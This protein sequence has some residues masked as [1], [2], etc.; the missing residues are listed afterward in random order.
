MK[1]ARAV[2]DEETLYEKTSDWHYEYRPHGGDK[3]G[4]EYVVTM[5]VV[6]AAEDVV[7][8]KNS[9]CCPLVHADMFKDAEQ[10]RHEWTTLLSKSAIRVETIKEAPFNPLTKTRKRTIAGSEPPPV[11]FSSPLLVVEQKTYEL[12]EFA[13]L[14]ELLDGA[15]SLFCFDAD[16]DFSLLKRLQTEDDFVSGG[17]REELDENETRVGRYQTCFFPEQRIYHWRLKTNDIRGEWNKDKNRHMSLKTLFFHHDIPYENNNALH[18]IRR[19]IYETHA[20]G[21]IWRD[22]SHC[23]DVED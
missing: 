11:S 10:D 15:T 6:S 20:W 1:R 5:H 2:K 4:R 17:G 23:E 14:G 3:E 22:V 13:Q 21:R 7:F 8:N 16:H 19:A 9:S 12:T 18:A